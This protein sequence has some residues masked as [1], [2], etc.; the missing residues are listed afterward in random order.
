MTTLYSALY[1]TEFVPRQEDGSTGKYQHEVEDT[2]KTRVKSRY[3]HYPIFKSDKA[4]AIAMSKAIACPKPRAEAWACLQMA[5][6]A[7]T[8]C[9]VHFF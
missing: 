9:S 3:R 2:P 7:K 6:S 8:K 5:E 1:C 4:L